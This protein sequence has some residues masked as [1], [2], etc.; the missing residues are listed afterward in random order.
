MPLE[1]FSLSYD[2]YRLRVQLG[3]AIK[4]KQKGIELLIRNEINEYVQFYIKNEIPSETIDLRDKNEYNLRGEFF[5]DYWDKLTRQ[6]SLWP[7]E[8]NN[9]TPQLG[10]FVL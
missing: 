3:S 6:P 10:S 5:P 7:N 8:D 2:L 4:Y 1:S 9:F